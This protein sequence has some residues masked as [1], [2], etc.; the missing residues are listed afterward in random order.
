MTTSIATCRLRTNDPLS[1]SC[2]SS[3]RCLA[4]SLLRATP[5]GALSR[6][7]CLGITSCSLRLALFARL[8]VQC[9][10]VGIS[11]MRDKREHTGRRPRT[12]SFVLWPLLLHCF[13]VFRD[14]RSVRLQQLLVSSLPAHSSLAPSLPCQRFLLVLLSTL[15]QDFSLLTSSRASPL[16]QKPPYEENVHPRDINGNFSACCL[17]KLLL[18]PLS[19]K[20]RIVCRCHSQ[21]P[22]ELIHVGR[23]RRFPRSLC[24]LTAVSPL[25]GHPRS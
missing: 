6:G 11:S 16:R 10:P 14:R 4:T 8:T 15:G 20:N 21:L 18:F 5:L 9:R 23:I 12:L 19:A 1:P 22:L 13:I 3:S 24:S 2:I 25:C 17:Q 7:R